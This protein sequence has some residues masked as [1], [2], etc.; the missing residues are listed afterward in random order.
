MSKALRF[1]NGI[2]VSVLL[3]LAPLHGVSSQ[4]IASLRA[5]EPVRVSMN[6]PGSRRVQGRLVSLSADTIVVASPGNSVAFGISDLALLQVKR[7]SG[8]SVAKSA[9]IGL[10]VGA[11]GTALI[12][13]ATGT[14]DTG[15][16]R[17]TGG[18]KAVIG[19]ILGG[20]AGLIGGTIFGACCSSDWQTVPLPRRQ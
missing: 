4:D 9:G 14:T 15:D 13:A 10:I 16:G 2:R 7:R 18:D 8:G 5:G 6:S 1:K 20:A 12:G 19:A 3:L 11:I 17:I